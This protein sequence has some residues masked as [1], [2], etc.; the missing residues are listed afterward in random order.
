MRKLILLALAALLVL[1]ASAAKRVTVEQL[2]QALAAD[3]AAHR[4]DAE[5]AR[6]LGELEL[7]ERL[8]GAT[9]ARFSAKLTLGPKA[10]LALQLLGDQSAFLDPPVSELPATAPPDAATQQRMMDAARGYVIQTVP[11]LIDFFA[12]RNTYRFDDSPQV[13]V[14]GNWPVRAGLHLAGSTGQEVTF[15]DGKESR[16]AVRPSNSKSASVSQEQ[17]EKGLSSWGE[18]GPA[19]AV[20]LTDAAKGS[21]SW[22]HWEETPAGLASV[23]H[24]SVPK[25]ASHYAVNYCCVH[26]NSIPGGGRW[27]HA[28]VGVQ[29]EI[30]DAQDYSETPGYHGSLSVDPNT[31]AILRI[32]IE[33]EMKS[34]SP[35][36]RAATVVEYGRIQIG[37]RSFI[38]PVRSLAV[39]IEEPRGSLV[40]GTSVGDWGDSSAN[41]ISAPA[42]L[43]NETRFSEYHRL[44]ATA[45]VVPSEMT[46]GLEAAE[47]RG[48]NAAASNETTPASV[49]ADSQQAANAN[50][51]P[52]VPPQAAPAEPFVPEISLTAAS[53]VPDEPPVSLP[54]DASVTLK[55]TTRLVDVGIVAYD[56]KGYPVKDL[57]QDD[58]EVYDNGRKQE[59][60]FFSQIGRDAQPAGA[61]PNPAE[62]VFSNRTSDVAAGVLAKSVPEAGATILLIDQSHI[63]WSDLSNARA[64]MLMFLGGLPTGERVGFYTMT[65]LGFRVLT[66]ITTDHQALIARLQKWMPSAQSVA[67]SQE[68]EARNRQQINE[69]QSV[70]D[71]KSVNGNSIDAPVS[72]SPVDY[73]L[74]DRGQN[75]ARDS[76]IVLVG[77]ARHLSGVAGHKN[78][79]WVSSDNVFADWTNQ[80]VGLEKGSKYLDGF[81]M[82]AQ[83]AMNDAHAAVF[84]FDVSQLEGGAIS[85]DMQHRMVE[86]TQAAADNAAMR[87]EDL[88]D[89]PGG[90]PGGHNLTPGRATAQMRQDIHPIQ[91]PIVEVAEATGGRTIRRSGD[92]AAALAGIV[93]DGH[94]KYQLSFSPQGPADDKYHIITVKLVGR[95]GLNL[96]YRTG[97]LFQKEPATLKDRFNQAIWR[98]AEMDEVA[99]TALVDALSPGATVKIKIAAGD[100]GLQQQDGR[101]MDKLDI[102]FIQRDD[103]GLHAQVEGQTLGLQLK[104][105]TYQSLLSG[106]VPFDHFVQLRPGMAS[107]RV[108]VVDEN[109]G[110]MGSVT[111]PAAAF[112]AGQ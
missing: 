78:L 21:V 55:H 5:V 46:A 2:E 60:R 68:E 77:V 93:E 79:V 69:V 22:S 1:P 74:R 12:I 90:M 92:L 109:S 49:T 66:E 41:P 91:Q 107:L 26:N 82:G 104:S 33:A 94:A 18:F 95:R 8:T 16:Q 84:P 37:D 88:S 57:K 81:A 9:L 29:L 73:Q 87:S 20:V 7:S 89:L 39:S 14:K 97:Y 72:N 108:L 98:P 6:Q 106:G 40:P 62:R 105:S 103:E 19:L 3:S 31:G 65:G 67:Q 76:L 13:L 10:A 64:Q 30:P 102:F 101:W 85:A 100:L 99:L 111:V 53:G 45:R 43:L 47:P 80:A 63:A 56:K 59:V 48:P 15:R 61:A 38:C 96:R 23:F 25:S 112:C 28:A 42:L 36:A 34:G 27:S 86:L 83:E 32:T 58:F 75:P 51:S 71:L 70:S 44:A 52:I 24:Y 4:D 50:A 11:H 17:R 35:L 54:R 110:R